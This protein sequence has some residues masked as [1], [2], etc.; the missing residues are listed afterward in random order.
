MICCKN[1]VF[2]A[3]RRATDV[4]LF[5]LE[6]VSAARNTPEVDKHHFNL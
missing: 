2:I 4:T 5:Q 1:N 3:E 6:D